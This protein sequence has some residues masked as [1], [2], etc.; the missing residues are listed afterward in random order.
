[1]G[2]ARERAKCAFDVV[3]RR[4]AHEER[5]GRP[6]SE[7]ILDRLENRYTRPARLDHEP[8]LRVR[9][10]YTLDHDARKSPQVGKMNLLGDPAG[11]D[12]GNLDHVR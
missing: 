11:S 4:R 3:L 8:T 5:I 7:E 10:D 6:R 2:S 9:V 12:H 1:M